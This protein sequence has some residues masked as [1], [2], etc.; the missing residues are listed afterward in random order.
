MKRLTLL[1]GAL[2]AAALCTLPDGG[3]RS[4]AETDEIQPLPETPG[5]RTYIVYD[6]EKGAYA[7]T[8]DKRG[9]VRVMPYGGGPVEVRS[10][11]G[12]A[13]LF[14]VTPHAVERGP[15][16][17]PQAPKNCSSR[18]TFTAISGVLRRSSRPTA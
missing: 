4:T 12:S 7:A 2:L 9:R 16:E 10:S 15:Q 18:P 5:R 6:A 17:L 3:R 13:Y 8:A 1:F 14:S 11:R